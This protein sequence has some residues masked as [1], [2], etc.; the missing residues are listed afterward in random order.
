MFTYV[1]PCVPDFINKTLNLI[2]LIDLKLN[3]LIL[4]AFP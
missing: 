3:K 1:G 2:S 4:S